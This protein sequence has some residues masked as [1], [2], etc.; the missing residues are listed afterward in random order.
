[1]RDGWVK[2]KLGLV[3]EFVM[4]QAPL[5]ERCNKVGIGT[6][7]VKAGEF[8]ENRPKIVEWT[9][10]PLKM[11]TSSDVLVCVVGATA[12]KINLGADCAI[13]RSVAAVRPG[14]KLH[15]LYLYYLLSL[16]LTNLRS[17]SRGSAQ[18][19][20]TKEDLHRIVIELPPLDEQK[21]IVDLTTSVDSYIERLQE[22]TRTVQSIRSSISES[23]WHSFRIRSKLSSFGETITGST[24]P[25][26]DLHYWES[27]D[28]DFFTPSD[29]GAGLKLNTAGRG[30]SSQG[31]AIS[32]PLKGYSVLQVCI[33]ATIGKV[34]FLNHPAVMNQQINAITNLTEHDAPILAA[35]LSSETFQSI[36]RNTAG[37]STLPIISKSS[38]GEI[39][40]PYVPESKRIQISRTILE[41]D[42]FI[43]QS[44]R[45][46][47]SAEKLRK[48]ILHNLLNGTH[49]IPAS[50]DREI[51]PA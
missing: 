7:F 5:G 9:T 51:S 19:V 28:V 24:P 26:K 16:E 43:Q 34:G 40:I 50:Y 6:P 49:E 17:G 33:G 15:Q 12:G 42:S 32:R 18:G 21:R 46:L 41:L 25:T 20:I 37:G 35:I 13:G 27:H 23:L 38:W 29:L 11:A 44:K 10:D 48:S 31:A 1:M 8:G 47:L 14:E 4:G 22:F 36:I 2:T 45:S 30:V 39:E 3:S